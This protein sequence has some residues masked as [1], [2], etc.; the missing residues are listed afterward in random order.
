MSNPRS[1]MQT[2]MKF[3]IKYKAVEIEFVPKEAPAPLS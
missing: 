3:S 1:V 2:S